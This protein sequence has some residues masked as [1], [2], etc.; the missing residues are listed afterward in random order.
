M[1]NTWS[2]SATCNYLHRKKPS[3]LFLHFCWMRFFDLR[4]GVLCVISW[5]PTRNCKDN[6]QKMEKSATFSPAVCYS[7][8]EICQLSIWGKIEHT[9]ESI[10]KQNSGRYF[11][12]SV[13]RSFKCFKELYWYLEKERNHLLKEIAFPHCLQV[14]KDKGFCRAG[15]SVL[16]CYAVRS[17]IC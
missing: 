1:T 11:P 4:F 14:R 8:T 15:V 17:E 9:S 13:F 6:L 2:S 16:A 12:D 10:F 3:L 7:G 5:F